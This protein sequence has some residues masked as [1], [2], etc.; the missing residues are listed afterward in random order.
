MT[1]FQLTFL[2]FLKQ[3]LNIFYPV[4]QENIY[5]IKEVDKHRWQKSFWEQ[6]TSRG[7][8]SYKGVISKGSCPKAIIS[9]SSEPAVAVFF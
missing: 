6:Q 8:S 1:I 4:G 2:N 7:L 9:L 3:I 5:E